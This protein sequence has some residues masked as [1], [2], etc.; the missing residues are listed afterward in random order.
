MQDSKLGLALGGLDP[1][2]ALKELTERQNE[3]VH[4]P[5]RARRIIEMRYGLRDEAP[6]TLL[7][8]ARAI[9][10]SPQLVHRLETESLIT[11]KNIRGEIRP[12]AVFP[13]QRMFWFDMTYLYSAR[14]VRNHVDKG[15]IHQPKFEYPEEE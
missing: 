1:N 3:T 14:E 4:D 5:N 13:R 10:R 11:L 2:Y 8:I 15:W 12:E 9:G 7:G 6:M